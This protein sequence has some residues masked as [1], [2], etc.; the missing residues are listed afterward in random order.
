[1]VYLTKYYECARIYDIRMGLTIIKIVFIINL[2]NFVWQGFNYILWKMNKIHVDDAD[3]VKRMHI[4]L[5]ISLLLTIISG[6]IFL[7]NV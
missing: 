4:I 1:M 2:L 7:L 6:G 3:A 5:F